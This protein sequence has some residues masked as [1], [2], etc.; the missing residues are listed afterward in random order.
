MLILDRVCLRPC[1]GSLPQR[2]SLFGLAELADGRGS[3][4]L[5]WKGVT[6]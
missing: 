4:A 5:G 1:S 3:A 2:M 6:P